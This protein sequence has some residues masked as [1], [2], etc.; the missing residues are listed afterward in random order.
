M[1]RTRSSGASVSP[2]AAIVTKIRSNVGLAMADAFGGGDGDFGARSGGSSE[3]HKKARSTRSCAPARRCT[4]MRKA[5]GGI[6]NGVP[7]TVMGSAGASSA[8]SAD[9]QVGHNA[10]P[11]NPQ[12]AKPKA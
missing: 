10:Y 7:A 4:A 12:A 8:V 3:G 9:G 6:L 2:A 11:I 1:V 5:E